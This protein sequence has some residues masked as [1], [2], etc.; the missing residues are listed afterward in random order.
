M[1]KKKLFQASAVYVIAGFLP[2]AANFLLAPIYTKYLDPES[3]GIIALANIF[4]SVLTLIIGL[5]L[6]SAYVRYYYDYYMSPKLLNGYFSTILLSIIILGG[7][8]GVILA[9]VGDAV[10]ALSFQ[11]DGFTFGRYG[12]WV[13]LTTFCFV[14]QA[15]FIA[16]YRNSQQIRKFVILNLLF[17]FLPVVFTLFGL[18]YFEL[19]AWGAIVGRTTGCLLVMGV[20]L[21]IYYKN[22][23]FILKRTYLVKSLEYSFP[24][25]LYQIVLFGF[26]NYDRILVE[27]LFNLSTLGIYNFAL[28]VGNLVIIFMS[29]INNAVV[30]NIYKLLQESPS[31]FEESIRKINVSFLI[32]SIFVICA[33][34]AV[35]G[36]LVRVFIN[37]SYHSIDK[38]IGFI[39]LSNIYYASYM[40]HSL[41]LFYNKQTKA[42]PVIS[43]IALV[44]GT[45]I[46]YVLA[47]QF[48]LV[49]ICIGVL[50]IRFLQLSLTRIFNKYLASVKINYLRFPKI[51][52][53]V[54]TLVITYLLLYIGN[55]VL[56][57]SKLTIDVVNVMPLLVF[58][59]LVPLLFRYELSHIY[60]VSIRMVLNRFKN[61]YKFKRN[62][63]D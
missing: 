56:I 17:F 58:S 21:I 59:V 52:I 54:T 19:G 34:A 53:L 14:L 42:F 8:I 48:G 38:Y 11:E 26:G 43:V 13:Y 57:S 12:I 6:S 35:A 49:G 5:S 33:C 39:F 30:P 55:E 2:L 15:L 32:I 24:I 45:G 23:P 29:S 25:L 28:I 40:V 20:F 31:G 60:S 51:D 16:E 36:P 4:Q 44:A 41:P 37:E 10:L 7:G 27:R 22:N 9:L 50:C 18:I 1:N 3:Y 46:S 62:F 61:V 63:D 47:I